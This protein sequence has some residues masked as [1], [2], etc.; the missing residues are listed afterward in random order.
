MDMVQFYGKGLLCAND[1]D[2]DECKFWKAI[3]KQKANKLPTQF[4]CL[5]RLS[6]SSVFFLLENLQ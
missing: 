1:D 2:D 6:S 5:Y 3:N 4:P